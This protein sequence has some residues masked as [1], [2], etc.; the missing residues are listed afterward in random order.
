M[1]ELRLEGRQKAI[2]VGS[3]RNIQ[4]DQSCHQY[5]FIFADPLIAHFLVIQFIYG[6]FGKDAVRHLSKFSR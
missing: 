4:D 6:G 1:A 2:G 3:S 5:M